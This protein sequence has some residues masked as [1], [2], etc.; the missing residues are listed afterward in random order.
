[1]IKTKTLWDY[2]EKKTMAAQEDRFYYSLCH[3]G[4]V[5]IEVYSVEITEQL[6][7]QEKFYRSTR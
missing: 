4:Y 3:C 6:R 2:K 5:Y 1:M 7:Y